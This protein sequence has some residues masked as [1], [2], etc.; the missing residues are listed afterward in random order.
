[1]EIDEK[2]SEGMNKKVPT[3]LALAILL[4]VAILAGILFWSA[5]KLLVENSE[6][7][8]K[9]G[10]KGRECSMEAKICPDGSSVGRTG[11]N[12]EFAPC[13]GGKN[14]TGNDRDE[15]GCIASAGYSWCEGKQK[16]LRGWEEDC[17]NN[18]WRTYRNEK[19]GF[20]IKVPRI[21]N[22]YDYKGNSDIKIMEQGDITW[23][24]AADESS[25]YKEDSA[26]MQK[27]KNDF[28]K[29]SGI[30]WAILTKKVANDAEL[31][32]FIQNRYGES[33]ELG[34]KT[35]SSQSGV[36]DVLVDGSDNCFMNFGFVIKYYPQKGVVSAWDLGQDSRFLDESKHSLDEE[37]VDSFK[38]L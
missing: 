32:K 6:K 26:Q 1:M 19:S 31:R 33:C 7:K 22:S 36:F 11:P 10:S 23:I 34:K 2:K 25:Y 29:V 17:V 35:S 30:P 18:D 21:A 27:A 16:C 4:L 3:A 8:L 24:A 13:S 20:T 37:M 38:F 12:C 14:L 5:G 15:H 9:K 28:D